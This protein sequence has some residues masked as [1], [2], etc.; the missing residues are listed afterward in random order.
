MSSLAQAR[1]ALRTVKGLGLISQG[2][3]LLIFKELLV[4]WT[5][6][7]FRYIFNFYLQHFCK[8]LDM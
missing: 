2:T 4:D 8:Y 3:Y 7:L 1:N 5:F 6:P